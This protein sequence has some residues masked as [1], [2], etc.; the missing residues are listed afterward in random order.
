M[1]LWE[2]VCKLQTRTICKQEAWMVC[3][4]RGRCQCKNNYQCCSE[5]PIFIKHLTHHLSTQHFWSQVKDKD[6]YLV[7][8]GYFDEY[9]HSSIFII[10]FSRLVIEYYE[11]MSGWKGKER[12]AAYTKWRK[13]CS[14]VSLMLGHM[15]D[16]SWCLFDNI[17]QWSFIG[18]FKDLAECINWWWWPNCM[19]LWRS[20]SEYCISFLHYLPS[21]N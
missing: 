11:A 1:L 19:D 20:C 5:F 9:E 3:W 8:S 17:G 7:F 16:S 6:G 4:Q 21:N 13:T 10:N 12:R 18:W 14:Q 15:A 2:V